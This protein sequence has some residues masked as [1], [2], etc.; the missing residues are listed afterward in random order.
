MNMR[1]N[2][3]ER[4]TLILK[5]SVIEGVM[6]SFE[7]LFDSKSIILVLFS[8]HV[9]RLRETLSR[10]ALYHLKKLKAG[11][12][13]SI[14]LGDDRFDLLPAG[15]QGLLPLKERVEVGDGVELDF[16]LLMVEDL[17]KSI[18]ASLINIGDMKTSKEDGAKRQPV[19]REI[20]RIGGV[21]SPFAAVPVADRSVVVRLDD[22]RV[23]NREGL[24][25]N[26]KQGPLD[27]SP[28]LPVGCVVDVKMM[29]SVEVFEVVPVTVRV[30]I[31]LEG[32]CDDNAHSHSTNSSVKATEI[33][34]QEREKLREFLRAGVRGLVVK[35]RFPDKSFGVF[36]HLQRRTS[37]GEAAV[38][39]NRSAARVKT[40]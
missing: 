39:Q 2:R 30:C 6:K 21:D 11:E 8:E 34:G 40:S 28:L 9:S 35:N 25:E 10:V 12:V 7:Q 26:V 37:E 32:A 13:R 33:G 22:R 27:L 18:G 20:V 29:S 24:L 31:E 14:V 23:R 19:T 3:I 17:D 36:G 1:G 5:M 4:V 16:R 38:R 15:E